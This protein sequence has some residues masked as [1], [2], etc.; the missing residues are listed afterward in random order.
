M[1]PVHRTDHQGLIVIGHRGASGY[2]PEHT[3]ES[4]RLAIRQGADFI[5]PDLVATRDGVLVARHENEISGTTDVARHPEFADRRTTK[6]ID[7]Q[8]MTGWFTEDFTLA[9]LKTL[10]AKERI[11]AVRPAN[12]RFDGMY[13]IPTFAEVVRLA[14]AESRDGRVIG[15]YPETKHPTYF[16]SEGRRLDGTPIGVSLGRKLVETLVAEGFTDPRRVYI[17]S[18]EVANLIELKKSIMPSAGVD[19]PLVQLFDDIYASG[20]Y[21]FHWNLANGADLGAIYGGLPGVIGGIEADT[22]YLALAGEPALQWMKANY[23]SGIGPWKVNLLPRAASPAK[24]DADGD[25]NAQLATRNHGLVHPLLA[26][27]LK[28]GLVVHPYTLRA[29]EPYLSQTPTGI[30]QSVIAEAVQ[31]YGLGV[32]GFFIDQ[33]DL[34][35]AARELFLEAS[36]PARVKP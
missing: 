30:N 11:P 4:Y 34:G 31:L 33:P 12:T 8:A 2:R 14:K 9:E 26:Q 1:T 19:F 13:Q 27:A 5:E 32:Q 25:G 21:D 6:R 28:A 36:K 23:A 18:F 16:A 22:Q 7:G 35:V 10:R 3:L 24:A 29:E 15:V 17:Q 20:P